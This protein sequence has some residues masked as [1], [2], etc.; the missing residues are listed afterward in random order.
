[1]GV[2][3]WQEIRDDLDLRNKSSTTRKKNILHKQFKT[4]DTDA[5]CSLLKIAKLGV[6]FVFVVFLGVI[7]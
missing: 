5:N 7:H 2:S 3:N 4:Y 1:M 6:L